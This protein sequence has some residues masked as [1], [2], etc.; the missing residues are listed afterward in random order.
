VVLLLLPLRPRVVVLLLLPL[1]PRV[2]VLLLLLLPL[3]PRVVER[4]RPLLPRAVLRRP[5]PRPHRG[6]VQLGLRVPPLALPRR[7]RTTR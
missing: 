3:R 4:L 5:R 1:R 2:V 6:S 7:A